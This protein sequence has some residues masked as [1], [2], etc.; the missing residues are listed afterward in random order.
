MD[1][2]TVVVHTDWSRSYG[3]QEIRILTELREIGKLG[4]ATGLI[5]PDDSELARRGREEGIPVYPV[6]FSS[7]FSLS[8]WAALFRVLRKIRPDIIN[9]HSSEDSWMAGFAS[10]L[11]KVPLVTRT[12]HV[13]APISSALSYNAFP[14]VIF[15]CSES[16]RQ[17]LID[18]GVKASRIVVQSTG[19]DEQRFC[20]SAQDRKEVRDQYGIG[21]EDILVGNVAFLRHYKGHPF[22]IKTAAAMPRQYKFMIVGGGG[23]LPALEAMVDAAGIRDR[24]IFAGHQ[25][26]PEK[27]FS[28]FDL[29]FFSS[30]ESEG[31]AQSFVQGLLYGLPVLLCRV[32]S[33]MEPLDVV[34]RYTVVDYNDVASACEG[35]KRMAQHLERNEEQ[36][37]AQ[38]QAIAEKY[39]LQ[40]MMANIVATYQRHGIRIPE[41]PRLPVSPD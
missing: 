12:R 13:L 29:V 7:K 4:F 23:E 35:L 38:R 11:C 16:I 18:Q 17:Q 6:A 33:L 19:I 5:V 8:S 27:F 10:R 21:E 40:A 1:K 14:H 37:A 31:I 30:Y 20:Y 2:K 32:P 41:P 28:A 24:V 15:A 3:G 25:E 26:H 9:T 22:I 34:S 39:G 36:V